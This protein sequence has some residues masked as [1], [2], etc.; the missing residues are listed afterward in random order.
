MPRIERL[1]NLIAALLEARRPMTAEEIR[2][3]IAGY[4]QENYETFRRA[5]ERDKDALR[6]MG[7][8]LEVRRV[9]PLTDQED[10]YLIPRE[11]YYLPDLDLAPEE[12]AA[13]AIATETLA[14]PAD[15]AASGMLKI[16]AVA[17]AS[18]G[19]PPRVVTTADVGVGDARLG[20]I[21]AGV[22]ERRPLS[23]GYVDAAGRRTERRVEPWAL[24]HRAGHWY[25]TGRDLQAGARRTFKVSRMDG[26]VLVGEGT[27][28]AP[29]RDATS[30]IGAEPWAFGGEEVDSVRVRFEAGC[31]WWA[32][33][34]LQHLDSAE[35]PEGSLEVM[36]TAAN[37]DA[38]VGWVLD[39]GGDVSV[40]APR[41]LAERVIAHLRPWLDAQ[42]G[43]PPRVP[44]SLRDSE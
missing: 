9:D 34:N 13:L 42:N 38:L 39:W 28:E 3:R 33:Q 30:G 21:Y 11:R 41:A 23:F 4:G 17:D 2:A 26:S 24:V 35:G 29:A 19:A 31:R 27:F 25:M 7:I 14:G 12:L 1:I 36:M 10:G 43:A 15:D 6:A 20:A 5:F 8:P 18:A 44:T 22:L 16:A 40:V 37:P 32:E